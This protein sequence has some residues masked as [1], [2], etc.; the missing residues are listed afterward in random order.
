MDVDNKIQSDIDSGKLVIPWKAV[1]SAKEVEDTYTSFEVMERYVKWGNAYI[2]RDFLYSKGYS[3][4]D[5]EIFEERYLSDSPDWYT[6]DE[7]LSE[8]RKVKWVEEGIGDAK[9]HQ[10]QTLGD[11]TN[12][13]HYTRFNNVEVIDLAEQLNYNKGN[14]IKYVSRAGFKLGQNEVLDLEKAKWYIE[15]E[16]ERVKRG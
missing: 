6:W 9:S 7:T 13:S 12:P 10:I 14:I 15:R 3:D 5:T 1:H 2:E 8:P 4:Y 11:P 16:I